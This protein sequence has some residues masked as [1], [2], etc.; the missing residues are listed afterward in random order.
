M[1][2]RCRPWSEAG[3]ALRPAWSTL[4][5]A[6]PAL[7]SPYFAWEFVDAVARHVP[8]VELAIFLEG[9]QVV[10]L[11]PFQRLAAREAAPVGTPLNDYQGVIAAVG[12]AFEPV[13]WLDACGLDRFVFDH[14]VVDQPGW[15]PYVRTRRQS[16]CLDLA[17]GF[18]AWLRGR[19]RLGR[20]RFERLEELRRALARRHGPLR[21]VF[22]VDDEAVLDAVLALKSHQYRRTLGAERDL[23]ARPE[24]TAIVRDIFHARAPGF[25]GALSA[26][27][28]GDTLVAAHFGM[29]SGDVLHWWFPTYAVS[30][31][32]YSPGALLLLDIARG[33][34]AAGIRLIDFGK[35]SEP[36]K[37]R[38]AT[39]AFEVAEGA[40]ER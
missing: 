40:V 13:A 33:A 2:I 23:F 32:R 34:A 28:S 20:S 37:L 19:R 17:A 5:A 27:W 22:D 39:G 10:A 11:L 9:T 24:M 3:E 38:W 7:R 16:P 12:F 29:G 6:N 18:D 8:G 1:E 15:H 21:F 35:G 4:R 14:L 36:Y 30:V 31:A 25:A 26:L